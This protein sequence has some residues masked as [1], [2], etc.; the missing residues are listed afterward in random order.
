MSTKQCDNCGETVDGAKAFCP[1]CGNS[2]IAEDARQSVS[3]FDRSAGTV[4]FGQTLFNEM[5]SDMGLNI[6]EAPTK[7]QKS[8]EKLEPE[9]IPESVVP[10]ISQKRTES[11][12]PPQP[13][14]SRRKWIIAAAVT[15][16]FL[17]LFAAIALIVG[18]YLYLRWDQLNF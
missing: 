11:V 15:F 3:E 18:V 10:P 12:P 16:M 9:K 1:A 13:A 2:F 7:P 6:S 14:R 8:V 4:Q 5:L 17:I